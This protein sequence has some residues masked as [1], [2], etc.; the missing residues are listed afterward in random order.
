M[1]AGACLAHGPLHAEGADKKEPPPVQ[2]ETITVVVPEGA[3]AGGA[4]TAKAGKSCLRACC[5]KVETGFAQQHAT[6]HRAGARSCFRRNETCS[7]ITEIVVN[8]IELLA[9]DEIRKVV[10]D[11]ALACLTTA[12]AQKILVAINEAHSARGYVTTQGYVPQQDI[13]TSA[14]FVINVVTGRVG[15]VIYRETKGDGGMPEAWRALKEAKGVGEFLSRVSELFDTLDN[16]LDRFQLLD[17]KRVGDL[18]GRLAMPLEAG[19]AVDL[20]KIQQ[21]IDQLNKAPSQ[22]AAAKLEAGE[23]PGTSDVIVN[24]P[25]KDSFRLSAGY[26][27]NGASLNNTGDTTAKRLRLDIAKDNWLGINDTWSTSLA[28][29]VNTNEVRGSV[30]V[31]YRWFTFSLDGGYSESLSPLNSYSELFS[32]TWTGAVN[33]NWL[34]IR[35]KEQQTSLSGGLNWRLNRRF[36]NSIELTPQTITY[37]RLGVTHIR[38]WDDRQWVVSLGINQGLDLL[39]ATRDPAVKDS[40]T[41]RAQFFKID[42]ASQYTQAFKGWG[43]WRLDVSG[44]WT[45]HPLYSDDQLVMGSITS[46]RGFTRLPFRADR[47]GIVRSEFATALPMEKFPESLKAVPFLYDSLAGTQIYAY[48]DF[49]MGRDIANRRDVS[50]G[51]LGAGLRYHYGRLTAELMMAQPFHQKGIARNR[52]TYKPEF[53]ATLTAKVF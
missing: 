50:R 49:G 46:I 10:A 8:G 53:Y 35:N 29:G 1:A 6:K 4:L 25:R 38:F 34:A 33:A 41:P 27:I 15:K 40:T 26:E 5:A 12:S 2:G 30:A 14:R 13:K 17:P 45:P 7:R 21:G 31:P 20:E 16:A 51:A 18:K 44:Q 37:A 52:D 43:T 42:A 24:V 3:E 19:E 23:K 28:G 36:V 48:A 39:D 32:Q 9:G 47:G 11:H 22:K